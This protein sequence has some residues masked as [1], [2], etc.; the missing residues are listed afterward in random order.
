MIFTYRDNILKQTNREDIALKACDELARDP[1]SQDAPDEIA[2]DWLNHFSRYAEDVSSETLQSLWAKILSGEIKRPGTF[3]ITTLQK[4]SA[5][6]TDDANKIH[7]LL[8]YVVDERFFYRHNDFISVDIA[9]RAEQ[10]GLLSTSAERFAVNFEFRRVSNIVA[11]QLGVK[12]ERVHKICFGKLDCHDMR[13]VAFAD[14]PA[15]VQIPAYSLTPF[16]EDL[17]RL[18][19]SFHADELYLRTVGGLIKGV[20]GTRVQLLRLGEPDAVTSERR[21]IST[22]E[23]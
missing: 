8:N 19:S 3:R 12:R 9:I 20:S 15:S 2:L 16:G 18:S 14:D 1:P 17:L 5:I 4:L 23:L 13:I 21:I 22:I 11:E 7:A 6:L 10:I